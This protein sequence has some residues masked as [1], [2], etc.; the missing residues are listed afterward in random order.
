MVLKLKI[1]NFDETLH[2]YKFDYA[3]FKY[4]NTFSNL[5]PKI[6]KENNFGPKF[7]FFFVLLNF[8]T[9]WQILGC[10]FQIS[11][12][13]F[14]NFYSKNTQKDIF[15][16]SNLRTFI[17]ARN[18]FKLATQNYTNK[19]FLIPKLKLFMLHDSPF[20]NF[21]GADPKYIFV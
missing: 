2:L 17:F 16:S 11:Q 3:G 10:W 1:F 12:S 5:L 7:D 6:P 8:F 18:F 14:I 9:F 21:V 20:H 19:A 13:F 4:D 15:F